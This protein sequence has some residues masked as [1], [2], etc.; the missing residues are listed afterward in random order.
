MRP[1]GVSIAQGWCP[2]LSSLPRRSVPL[3]GPARK[4]GSCRSARRAARPSR[5][6]G[7]CFSPC[8]DHRTRAAPSLRRATLRAASPFRENSWIGRRRPFPSR[9][10]CPYRACRGRRST[11]GARRVRTFLCGA[12]DEL[13]RGGKILG[14]TGRRHHL[15]HGDP[16]CVGRGHGGDCCCAES[17]PRTSALRGLTWDRPG[18]G[19][20]YS[21]VKAWPSDSSGSC[22]G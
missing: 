3:P 20:L 17:A 19:D 10:P 5:R 21:N 7:S 9:P 16:K 14:D 15:H 12:R 11:R 22:P 1:K 6:R 8:P 4:G 18:S 13:R 2:L